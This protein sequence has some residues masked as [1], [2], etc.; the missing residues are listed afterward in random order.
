MSPVSVTARIL[1]TVFAV[2]VLVGQAALAGEPCCHPACIRGTLCK[3]DTAGTQ[4][5]RWPLR[6]GCCVNNAGDCDPKEDGHPTG[7]AP[8]FH[9][10]PPRPRLETLGPLPS[11]PAPDRGRVARSPARIYVWNSSFLC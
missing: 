7:S 8:D 9:A 2:M 11:P 3:P 5:T 10:T 1:L 6:D 4:V